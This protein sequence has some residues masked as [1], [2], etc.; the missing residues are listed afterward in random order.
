MFAIAM[1]KP[2]ESKRLNIKIVSTIG[3]HLPFPEREM[4]GGLVE[5]VRWHTI[6]CPNSPCSVP[7]C[8]ITL[9][10]QSPHYTKPFRKTNL[11]NCPSQQPADAKQRKYI[12]SS[13][14]LL[15]GRFQ[16][17]YWL[18]LQAYL[19][20]CH[21]FGLLCDPSWLPCTPKSF[22]HSMTFTHL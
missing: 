18:W 13:H 7:T 20:M 15:P 6:P 16:S 10:S 22:F 8:S 21:L 5:S 14:Q 4:S 17:C 12:C 2:K 11:A 1:F 3:L 19:G 9:Q